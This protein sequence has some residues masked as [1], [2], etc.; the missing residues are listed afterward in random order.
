[1]VARVVAPAARHALGERDEVVFPQLE[2]EKDRR[3]AA[4]VGDQVGSPRAHRVRLTPRQADLLLGLPKE[5]AHTTLDDEERVLDARVV[6]P[7]Y[8]L[9]RADL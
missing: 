9:P 3:V 4:A 6:V 1:M 5:D 8:G 7:G 2:H